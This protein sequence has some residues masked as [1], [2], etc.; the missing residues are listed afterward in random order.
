MI[1]QGC[2]KRIQW[3]A[4]FQVGPNSLELYITFVQEGYS[5]S[6]SLNARIWKTYYFLLLSLFS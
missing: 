2:Y 6:S 1:R 3:L 4:V 5:M